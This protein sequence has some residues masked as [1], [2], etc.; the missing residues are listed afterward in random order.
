MSLL[1]QRRPPPLFESFWLVMLV[2]GFIQGRQKPPSEHV[3]G[4]RTVDV[5]LG[6]SY[7]FFEVGNV[8][9]EILP[10]HFDPLTKG[11]TCLLFLEGVSE[12]SIK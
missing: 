1:P 3:N 11:H 4:L 6:V 7:K 12:L 2:D 9:I 10:L 8:P 5:V